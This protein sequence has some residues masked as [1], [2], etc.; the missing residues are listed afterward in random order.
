[1]T[2]QQFGLLIAFLFVGFGG[3]MLIAPERL[4]GL[5]RSQN[6]DRPWGQLS[7]YK[8]FTQPHV[9]IPMMRM[10]G[11]LSALVGLAVVAGILF[12]A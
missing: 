2:D 10:I 9:Y 5:V 4:L 8:Q 7:L 11:G 6:D 1:M 12:L 3:L